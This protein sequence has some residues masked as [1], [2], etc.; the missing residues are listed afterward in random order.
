MIPM[1]Y[2]LSAAKPSQLIWSSLFTVHE[3]Q[4]NLNIVSKK[5][6]K[7]KAHLFD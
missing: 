1:S 3:W 2:E 7:S 6:K 4:K 5:G